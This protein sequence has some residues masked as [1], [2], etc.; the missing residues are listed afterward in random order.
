MTAP[1]LDDTA[2]AQ[3]AETLSVALLQP[4]PVEITAPAV[5]GECAN[6]P[7]GPPTPGALFL[8]WRPAGDNRWVFREPCCPPCLVANVMGLAGLR[9]W[10]EVPAAVTR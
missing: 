7:P 8:C 4:A 10:V 5:V 2:L 9:A 3:L 6:C 1:H